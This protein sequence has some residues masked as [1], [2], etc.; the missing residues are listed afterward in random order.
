MD[1]TM[2][3]LVRRGVFTKPL[4]MI[5]AGKGADCTPCSSQ[6]FQARFFDQ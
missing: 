4:S 1:V 3:D 2:D 6:P 5:H